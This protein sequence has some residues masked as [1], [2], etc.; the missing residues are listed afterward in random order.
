MRDL[1]WTS[2]TVDLGKVSACGF[3]VWTGNYAECV[4]SANVLTRQHRTVIRKRRIVKSILLAV[5][6]EVLSSKSFSFAFSMC[7]MYKV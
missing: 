2:Y 7:F 6:R 5:S 1:L 4:I 3:P